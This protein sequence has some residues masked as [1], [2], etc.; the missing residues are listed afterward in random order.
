MRKEYDSCAV[1]T[2]RGEYEAKVASCSIAQ[3][4]A[5]CKAAVHSPCNGYEA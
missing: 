5:G 1:R 3:R 4:S 2:P